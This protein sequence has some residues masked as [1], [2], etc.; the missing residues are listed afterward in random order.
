M[1]RGR[2]LRVSIFELTAM[3]ELSASV[4]AD[5]PVNNEVAFDLFANLYIASEIVWTA[6]RF[7]GSVSGVPITIWA[8]H[9]WRKS[10]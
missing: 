6:S 2:E 3:L 4:D 8:T 7:F 1:G 9:H 5:G 10:A